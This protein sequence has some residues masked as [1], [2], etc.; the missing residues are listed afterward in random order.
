[1]D[2]EHLTCP[3]A[4]NVED[5]WASDR[6]C[7]GDGVRGRAAPAAA[8]GPGAARRRPP[9]RVRLGLRHGQ[10]RQG[11]LQRDAGALASQLR[12][13]LRPWLVPCFEAHPLLTLHRP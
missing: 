9:R 5:A 1:M 6:F 2:G 10:L 12:V 3:S 8:P 11:K 4:A 7:G 13:P